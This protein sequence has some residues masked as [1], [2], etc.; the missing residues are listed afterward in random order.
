MPKIKSPTTFVLFKKQE[1][2]CWDSWFLEEDNAASGDSLFRPDERPELDLEND[3][4]NKTGHN[5]K[6][7][8]SISIL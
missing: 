3:Y 8:R 6:T 4:P 5:L 7:N 1:S 2:N